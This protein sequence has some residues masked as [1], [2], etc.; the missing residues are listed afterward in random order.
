MSPAAIAARGEFIVGRS[1]TCVL[2]LL[3]QPLLYSVETFIVLHHLVR[4]WRTSLFQWVV[5]VAVVVVVVVVPLLSSISSYWSK[6]INAA[7]LSSYYDEAHHEL[8]Y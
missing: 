7:V 3:C 2:L 4:G 1:D 5:V 8:L 6:K